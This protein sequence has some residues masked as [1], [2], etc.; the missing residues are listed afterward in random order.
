[1]KKVIKASTQRRWVPFVFAAALLCSAWLPLSAF[2]AGEVVETQNVNHIRSQGTRMSAQPA[3]GKFSA[4]K[5]ADGKDDSSDHDSRWSSGDDHPAKDK[6]TWLQATFAKPTSLSYFKIVFE[7][8]DA[9]A[10]PTP[11]N[12]KAFD[13][14]YKTESG[15]WKL[16]TTYTRTGD[17]LATGGYDAVVKVK[18]DAPI[19]AKAVRLTNFD[20][21][22]GSTAWNGVSVAEFEAYTN[23]QADAVDTE[24]VNHVQGATAKANAF[25][26]DNLGAD[27]AIDGKRGT[28][29]SSGTA[30]P[31]K[32]TSTYLEVDLKATSKIGFLDI[33]F[34][35]R[36]VDVKPSNVK[37]FEIQYQAPGSSD[38]VPV[39]TVSNARNGSGYEPRVRVTLEAP[40]VAKKIRL[41]NFDIATVPSQSQWNGVS[42]TEFEAYTNVQTA[43]ETLESVVSKLNRMGD[44]T[45]AADVTQ[46]EAPEVPTGFAIEFNGADFEQV[47][48]KGGA[49]HHPLTDKIVQVSWKVSKEGTR[50]QAITNDIAYEVKGTTA[51]AQGNARPTVVPEIQEWFS[52]STDKL[53]LDA[54]TG[55]TYGDASLKS[56]VDEFVADY[57]DFTGKTLAASQGAARAGAF[58]FTLGDPAGDKLLG[59]EGYAMQIQADRIDVTAPAITG[60][61]YAMQTIL[62]MTKT[63]TD[64]FP[65]GEMRDY[66]RFPVRG[67][68]WDIARKPV[69]LEM[70]GNA[71][72]TMR[73]YKMNDL[74][75]HL[76][77]NLIFLESYG[78]NE[79]DQWGAYSAFRLESG[80]SNNGVSPTAKDYNITKAAMRDFIKTQRDLGMNVVPEID[81]PAHAVA[82]TRVWPELAV[83]NTKVTTSPAGKNRSAIDHLDVR[84]P[85]AR[86][87]IRDIF[88]DYTTGANPVFDTDTVVHVGADEFIIPNGRPS[89][90]EFYNDLVPH[91]LDSGHTP[92]IWGSFD[93]SWL[94]GGGTEPQSGE[95]V[96]M[97]IWSLGWAN[98]KRMFDKGFSLINILDNPNYMVPNGG[99]NRGAY[100]DY[101]DTKNVYNSLDP[102]KFGNTVLP[103]SDP[104]ILGA[105]FAIW[106][107]NIDTNACG[108]S[109]ADEYARFFDALPVYAENNWAPTGQEK[110]QGNAGHENLYNI[111]KKTGDAPRV[112]PHSKASKTGDSYAEY[113]F[114]N[115]LADASKN[116]R[117]LK[118]GKNATV[119]NGELN[120]AGG[121]SYVESPL[122][123]IGTGTSLSFDIELTRPAC[124]GDI[125]FEAD[126]PYGTLDIRVMDN[127][128]L[129]FTRELYNY[130]FDYKLPVGKKV[131]V[132]IVTAT[133]K[134]TLKVDGE[135]IGEASG[136]FYNE[137]AKRVTKDGIGNS[138]FT[139]PLQRIGSKTRGIAAEIDSIKVA[140]AS[141]DKPVD[142]YNKA[143]W[144]ARTNSWT[145]TGESAGG[146]L[147]HAL[148]GNPATIW[149]SN[150]QSVTAENANGDLKV[151]KMIYAEFDFDKGYDIT[152]FSFTPRSDVGSGFITK[153]TLKVK[154]TANGEY[155]TVATDQVFRAD[156]KKKTFIFDEQTVYGIRLEIT[157]AN[158]HGGHKYVAVSEFDIANTPVRANTVYAHGKSYAAGTDGALDL[159]TGKAAGQIAGSAEDLDASKPVYRAEV[160]GGTTVTLTAE[161]VDGLEFVGWFAPCSKEPVSTDASCKVTADHNVA[162][163][164][165][166]KRIGGDPIVPPA[167][168][169]EPQPDPEPEPEP[170]PQPD[171]EQQ[172]GD[173]PGNK[174]VDKPSSNPSGQ[175]GDK[176]VATGDVSM[177]MVGTA[178]VG[179][180]GL[181]AAGT[182]RR[183]G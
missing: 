174:P 152:Q 138:T 158:E 148:D 128:K 13:I 15:D 36:T 51:P 123:K 153:A 31:E 68:M 39:K 19:E 84:K 74:Q 38:W 9:G 140:P 42:V 21:L 37:E 147:G 78:N 48:G 18:L 11:S 60:N 156:S 101:L 70:V 142:Q 98:P 135:T 41:T 59:E 26:A 4:D 81:M 3:G 114:D 95:G 30:K 113:G 33:E 50:E 172:T 127:G 45:V 56:V 164:A 182:K 178:L 8:R 183:R 131:H 165:R 1:M 177:A 180:M 116:G 66:P 173:R 143:K 65:V 22:N 72:R 102:N 80:L 139:L 40:I 130:Y 43:N 179:G 163:E 75:L 133:Q 24:N 132:E 57:K 88:D 34:E 137:F 108:L 120:L 94:A 86:K 97:D 121:A 52:N 73:Y 129:G 28:R 169:P 32:N 105:G 96:Q 141:T 99:G 83:K 76:S 29:W 63:E 144:Q 176:L 175:S 92:R 54:L 91:L 109:E 145:Q 62:Q 16:A 122:D 155:K 14:E 89:Y 100:G 58:N 118:A 151:S 6:N 55:V 136:S 117:D 104:R 171:P 85:E 167:P 181:V 61:M 53:G 119:E 125:L 161:Q 17:P 49:V 69:S 112:N 20:V 12:V 157:D 46:I 7:T 64:G 154:N 87:L 23:V 149:H 82:F 146:H 93:S 25:E 103:S 10:P 44:Q 166:Y 124:P 170:A 168:D 90:C 150:W 47:I 2:A 159:A 71:A 115:G 126:A 35:E 5:A 67:F 27:K 107:D 160:K 111:V 77:D 79:A 162:L 106:N 134:T 110:G